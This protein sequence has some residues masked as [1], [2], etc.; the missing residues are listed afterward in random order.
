MN[1]LSIGA[2]FGIVVAIFQKG[3]GAGLIG[4]DTKAPIEAFLPVMVF[5]IVFGLSMDYE[6]F[7]MSR[8][9]EEWEKRQDASEAVAR[10]LAA[11]GRVITAAAT[12][13]VFVFASFALGDDRVIKLF[14]IGLASAVLIDAVVI[15]THPRAVDHG[16][17]AEARVVAPGLARP[18]LAEAQRRA[19]ER[20][21]LSPSPPR[22]PA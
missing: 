11:T 17:A 21:P 8:I 15:R 20:G 12:I 10:G 3:W 2:S 6:V 1:L 18:H 13:M 4:V 14:G 9:H 22:R 7:L 5:A 16:P 19:A